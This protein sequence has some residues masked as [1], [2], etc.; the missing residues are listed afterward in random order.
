MMNTEIG[1]EVVEKKPKEHKVLKAL[2]PFLAVIYGTFISIVSSVFIWFNESLENELKANAVELIFV[3]LTFVLAVKLLPK[4]FPEMKKFSFGKPKWDLILLIALCTP[5]YF[6]VKNV[7]IYFVSCIFEKP[8]LRLMTYNSYELKGDLIASLSAVVLAPI[9]EELCF[10]FIPITIYKKRL[11]RILV[12]II[13]ALLFAFLHSDN[14][15]SV[16]VDAL[17]YC[18]LLLK[19]RNIWTNI[20][21]HSCYNLFVTILAVITY[22]GA[23]IYKSEKTPIVL[24]FPN[25][26]IAISSVLA[27]IGLVIFFVLRKRKNV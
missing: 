7:L 15:I 12:G 24:L 20:C 21:A 10:R 22:Y 23:E 4:L 11:T 27:V 13:M 16:T 18:A 6:I 17:L 14:W 9:Y 8:E 19:T 26:I 2:M 3:V 5:L 25:E 1:S